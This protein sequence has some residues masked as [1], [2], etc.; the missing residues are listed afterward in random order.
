MGNRKAFGVGVLGVRI[1]Q[2]IEKMKLQESKNMDVSLTGDDKKIVRVLVSQ[3]FVKKNYKIQKL[4][5]KIS[6]F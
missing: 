1:R 3:E 6:R 2:C 4:L 5:V